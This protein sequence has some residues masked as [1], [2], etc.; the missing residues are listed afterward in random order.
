MC[1]LVKVYGFGL[2]VLGFCVRVGVRVL[3]APDSQLLPLLHAV[4]ENTGEMIMCCV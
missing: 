3:R 1:L 2:R 4:G